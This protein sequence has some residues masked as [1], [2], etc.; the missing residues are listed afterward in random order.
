M[1]GLK[2]QLLNILNPFRINTDNIIFFF[3]ETYR[4]NLKDHPEIIKFY[5]ISQLD[6]D[7]AL[8][9]RQ[10]FFRPRFYCI[11]FDQ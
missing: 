5:S 2:I 10:I 4:E 1:K 8:A 9:L 3:K 7:S 6:N 11:L